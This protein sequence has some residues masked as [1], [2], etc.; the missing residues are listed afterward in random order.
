M[1][2]CAILVL[3]V[4]IASFALADLPLSVD[5]SAAQQVSVDQRS[6]LLNQV[7][8]ALEAAGY[9]M[10]SNM[11]ARAEF[12]PERDCE[13]FKEVFFTLHDPLGKLWVR[14]LYP[15]REWLKSY[16][17][18]PA[19]D[20]ARKYHGEVFAKRLEDARK[21]NPSIPYPEVLDMVARHTRKEAEERARLL[22]SKVGGVDLSNWRCVSWA[23]DEGQWQLSFHPFFGAY[24]LKIAS[25]TVCLSDAENLKLCEYHNTM[26][27]PLPAYDRVPEVIDQAEAQRL[28]DKY[29][30]QYYRHWRSLTFSTIALDVVRPNYYFT[31]KFDEKGNW[32][33]NRPRWSWTAQYERN[34]STN[35]FIFSRTPVW[36]YVDAETGEMLGGME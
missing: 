19:F 11:S 26:L 10:P 23:F 9:S 31:D 15:K 25:V 30:K 3:A 13:L 34:F 33:T 35:C 27:E 24:R 36:I 4:A 6:Q 28:A 8:T 21:A 16:R 29:L 1:K 32:L 7:L 2:L 20:A 5:W 17:N 18:W 12:M 22:A 14:C